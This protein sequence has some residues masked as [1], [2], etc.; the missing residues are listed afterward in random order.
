MYIFILMHVLTYMLYIKVVEVKRAIPR[1]KFP[2]NNDNSAGVPSQSPSNPSLSQ[3]ILSNNKQSIQNGTKNGNVHRASSKVGEGIQ[4]VPMYR[5][6]HHIYIYIYMLI[7]MHSCIYLYI[8]LYIFLMHVIMDI[9]T[10]NIVHVL[11]NILVYIYSCIYTYTYTHTYILI[12]IIS[13]QPNQCLSSNT[14][15]QPGK[16][17]GCFS[18]GKAQ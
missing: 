5:L 15:Q 14:P 2:N 6:I 11:I 1:T 9:F 8:Y 3:N 18:E 17:M 7:Y 13:D 12:P 16:L 4:K 10:F